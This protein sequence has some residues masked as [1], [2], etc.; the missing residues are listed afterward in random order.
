MRLLL[1]LSIFLGSLACLSGCEEKVHAVEAAPVDSSG[2]VFLAKAATAFVGTCARCA[3]PVGRYDNPRLSVDRAG[4]AGVGCVWS[5]CHACLV[6][7]L[8]RSK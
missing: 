3:R 1:S 2:T 4:F 7:T 5:G 6:E 8:E